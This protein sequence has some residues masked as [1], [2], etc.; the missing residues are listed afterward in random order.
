MKK[1]IYVGVALIMAAASFTSCKKDTS[2]QK[3][4]VVGKVN[5]K[6]YSSSYSANASYIGNI[7]TIGTQG[8]VSGD[9]YPTQLMITFEQG[10]EGN[11]GTSDNMVV[12][13]SKGADA[14]A[15]H[16]DDVLVGSASGSI[17]VL[18][19]SECKG[20]FSATVKTQSGSKTFEITDGKYWL[21][22]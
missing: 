12:S 21:D 13:G 17:E 4:K 5:G 16:W 11:A 9:I 1:M 19:S 14:F 20:T 3:G 15:T 18:N 7:L 2:F 22:I 6:A 10:V 8:T